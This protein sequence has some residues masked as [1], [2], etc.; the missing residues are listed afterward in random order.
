MARG[1]EIMKKALILCLLLT[2]CVSYS[3]ISQVNKKVDQWDTYTIKESV[4]NGDKTTYYFFSHS[5]SANRYEGWYCWESTCDNSG[6]ILA[7]KEY[8]IGTD[9]ALQDVRRTKLQR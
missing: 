7:K 9:M 8:W 3:N 5:M 4:Q 2:A 6:T 1:G